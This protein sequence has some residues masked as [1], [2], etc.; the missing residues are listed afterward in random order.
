MIKRFST[1]TGKNTPAAIFEYGLSLLR[2]NQANKAFEHIHSAAKRNHLPAQFK[3]AQLFL[4]GSDFYMKSKAITEANISSSLSL[5]DDQGKP[6]G[7]ATS[8]Q[9][10]IKEIKEQRKENL[11]K[12]NGRKLKS[13]KQDSS[14]AKSEFIQDPGRA[15][16]WLDTV[17]KSDIN[18]QFLLAKVLK[19]QILLEN[20]ENM[21]QIQ[22]ETVNSLLTYVLHC[23]KKVLDLSP[24]QEAHLLSAKK[25]ASFLLA[26]TK[27]INEGED[28]AI[29]LYL[30]S[31]YNY[32]NL[33]ALFFLSQY[34]FPKD[35]RRAIHS[36]VK[37]AALGHNE[38]CLNVFKL[39]HQSLADKSMKEELLILNEELA[40]GDGDIK[41]VAESFLDKGL[42]SLRKNATDEIDLDLLQ[43]AYLLKAE[44]II[45]NVTESAQDKNQIYESIDLYIRAG[46]LGSAQGYLCAGSVYYGV[47]G[48]YIRAFRCYEKAAELGSLEAYKNLAD[49]YLK[50]DGVVQC[51]D[52]A[53]FIM[54]F[55]RK[56]N[57][58]K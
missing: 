56:Q 57:E 27:F 16:F 26:T 52:T 58:N 39:V 54:E 9:D 45:A 10:V 40:S 5:I 25:Q 23:P 38:A 17:I 55:L 31:F 22:L 20:N 51:T 7:G 1:T 47:L 41:I 30:D 2:K 53:E 24:E 4:S 8:A 34:Y 48:D 44:C 50:G 11:R 13:A 14:K 15:L 49:M 43:E 21:N 32:K 46:E 12:L 28:K 33:D 6:T 36:L 42:N 18:D 3:V 19:A 37:A 35:T 29:P